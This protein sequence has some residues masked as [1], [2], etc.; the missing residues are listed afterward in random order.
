MVILV[1]ALAGG[2]SRRQ[3][4]CRAAGVDRAL[5][6]GE[7]PAPRCALADSLAEERERRMDRRVMSFLDS[8]LLRCGG[9]GGADP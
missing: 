1:T 5:E 8:E 4:R 9:R 7:A 2:S 6:D 3:E